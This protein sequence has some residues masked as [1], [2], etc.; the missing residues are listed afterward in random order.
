M[1]FTARFLAFFLALSFLLTGC[2]RY[3]VGIRFVDT[4]HGQLTQQIRL[5]SQL[6]EGVS[7]PVAIAWLEQ[8][9]HRTT[10]LGGKVEHLSEQELRLR[11]PF[12]NATDLQ[13][14]FSAFLQLGD[15]Q[16][17]GEARS[18]ITSVG[19]SRVRLT[20]GNWIVRQRQR[21]VLDID[22]RSVKTMVP[23]ELLAGGRSLRDWQDWENWQDWLDVEL[24]LSTPWGAKIPKTLQAKQYEFNRKLIWHLKP[25]ELNHLEVIFWLPNPLGTGF[26]IILGLV[27]GSILIRVLRTPASEIVMAQRSRF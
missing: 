21:L 18:P 5:D 22:L 8:L 20:S 24:T 26:L 1:S 19:E 7:R 15:L 10:Q 6:L 25:G 13:Q 14:K 16:Q 27:L 9:E 17:L 12:F 11:L 23:A 4:N 2:V 3:D